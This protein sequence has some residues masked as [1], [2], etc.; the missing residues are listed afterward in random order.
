MY[1]CRRYEFLT[2][3]LILMTYARLVIR[4]AEVKIYQNAK[5]VYFNASIRVH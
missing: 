4:E 2:H 1:F 5:D 3:A